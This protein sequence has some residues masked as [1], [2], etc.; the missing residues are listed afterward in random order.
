MHICYS[1][2]CTPCNSRLMRFFVEFTPCM[3]SKLCPKVLLGCGAATGVLCA[4]DWSCFVWC[5]ALLLPITAQKT[6]GADFW[7]S[8]GLRN[9]KAIL[10]VS[11]ARNCLEYTP[12]CITNELITVAMGKGRDDNC[13]VVGQDSFATP[14]GCHLSTVAHVCEVLWQATATWT[15]RHLRHGYG[16]TQ[17]C[18]GS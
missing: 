18:R 2:S 7:Q 14:T 1:H 8:G 9:G 13:E 5:V 4:K 10:S 16:V 6:A 11:K 3:S 15:S 12:P 17:V